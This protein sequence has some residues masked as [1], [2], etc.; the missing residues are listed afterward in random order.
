[1]HTRRWLTLVLAAIAMLAAAGCDRVSTGNTGGEAHQRVTTGFGATVVL[2]GPAREGRSI[3][4]ALRADLPVET[5]Y[6]GGFVN[7]IGDVKSVT[8]PER[9]D[10]FY[11]LN[12]IT[13]AHASSDVT[14]RPGD[15]VWWDYRP[16]EGAE[17]AWAVVG[18]WPEP[19]VHG[20]SGPAPRVAADAPLDDA[21]RSAGAVIVAEDVAWRVRVGANDE[22]R[23]RDPAW[24]R[25]TDNQSNSGLT[26]RVTGT[27]VR[28]LGA[29]GRTWRNVPGGRA[30]AAAVQSG[31]VPQ[32][33]IL[34]AVA[35]VDAAAAQAAAARIA[36]DPALLT[37][38]YAVVF[39]AEG[40]PI[41]A[42]G[43]GP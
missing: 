20:Y 1:M 16:W 10:W 26:A 5:A 37:G 19:F 40:N 2:D 15:Q 36:A 24:K 32:E 17:D 43:V 12:G 9:R 41:A 22:L 28:V 29:D 25:A 34:L 27:F 3:L 18:A 21:L 35:G 13:A 6:G 42:G 39:D 30:L 31:D 38:K 23:R 33:G 4:D 14:L 11:Y 8:D 7:A